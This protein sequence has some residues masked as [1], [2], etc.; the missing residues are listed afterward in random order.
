MCPSDKQEPNGSSPRRSTHTKIQPP[1]DI[2]HSPLVSNEI[3]QQV[4]TE[5]AQTG[6]WIRLIEHV[7]ETVAATVD[8][9]QGDGDDGYII[10]SSIQ[11]VPP[12]LP[13]SCHLI[14][15]E[16]AAVGSMKHGRNTIITTTEKPNGNASI[17]DDDPTLSSFQRQLWQNGESTSTSNTPKRIIQATD[18]DDAAHLVNQ[19]VEYRQQIRSHQAVDFMAK[20]EESERYHQQQEL[21]QTHQLVLPTGVVPSFQ[22]QRP[23]YKTVSQIKAELVGAVVTEALDRQ[24]R[25][26]VD[27]QFLVRTACHCIYCYSGYPN[28]FQTQAYAKLR[29]RQGWS[30]DSMRDEETE[31]QATTTA[32]KTLTQSKQPM[33]ATSTTTTTRSKTATTL[34]AALANSVHAPVNDPHLPSHFRTV[35]TSKHHQRAWKERVL[36]HQAPN[37]TPQGSGNSINDVATSPRRNSSPIPVWASPQLR[38]RTGRI[39]PDAPLS[40]SAAGSKTAFTRSSSYS[41]LPQE[42]LQV[43]QRLT[44]PAIRNKST[45]TAAGLPPPPPLSSPSSPPL[46]RPPMTI[47]EQ[48]HPEIQPIS[49]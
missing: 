36:H 19:Y 30:D 38:P 44:S 12:T 9:Q 4:A 1:F 42:W 14:I 21:Y 8:Q 28:P 45:A 11:S 33:A 13:T 31:Q 20:A 6:H 46:P 35:T 47:V 18:Q 27:K 41:S 34:D 26:V 25:L 10:K 15:Q 49:V 22:R 37:N 3:R 32:T 7:V 48:Q 17:D 5:A 40:C 24:T 16:A 29:S 43:K 23:S 39:N 2:N